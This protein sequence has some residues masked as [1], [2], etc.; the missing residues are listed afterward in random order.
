MSKFAS[1]LVDEIY[2]FYY[3]YFLYCLVLDVFLLTLDG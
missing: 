3:H 2:Y 1:G